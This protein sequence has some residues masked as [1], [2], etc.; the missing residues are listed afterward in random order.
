MVEIIRRATEI[1]ALDLAVW[2]MFYRMSRRGIRVD[3]GRL[4]A[5]HG[6]VVDLR[7]AAARKVNE[8]AGREINPNSGDE[9]AAW[10]VEHGFARGRKTKSKTRL[11][12]DEKALVG[13][14]YDHP[15]FDAVIEYRG[16]DKLRAAFIEPL[17]A[18]VAATDDHVVHP[19]WK[20]T[21]V[22]SGRAASEDPNLMAFPSRDELGREIRGCFVAR[23]GKMLFS[24]DYSQ[25]EPRLA[26]ALSSDEKLCAVYREGR[27]IYTET[28]KALF[29]IENVDPFRH[30]LP[31][32]VVTLGVMYGIG[33]EK[34]YESLIGW[35]AGDLIDGHF[36]PFFTVEECAELAAKWF[37]VYP[38]VARYIGR[39]CD[40]ARQEGG[41]VKTMRGRTRSLPA[42]FLM[43]GRWPQSKL[44][45]E[46]QRQAFNH[47]IQ[48]TAQEEMKLGMIRANGF[49]GVMDPL[50]QIHDEL[51]GEVAAEGSWGVVERIAKAM[52]AEVNGIPLK[53]SFKLA[54]N[55]GELK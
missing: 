27:D 9:V 8:A 41:V 28:A 36:K 37:Q 3:L 17:L 14:R 4:E 25:I 33:A 18:K 29:H 43:G 54:A 20:L 44:R 23:R 40:T 1:E 30:R 15:F 35:G 2:P 21:R 49:S 6:K 45:E 10:M 19:K 13:Y 52:E 39:V 47:V 11:S 22:R 53:T 42:L 48:G 12:T 24:V 32:K 26:A 7:T 46:A 5:L 34:L 31:A 50:L 16:H 38:G 55:W 51:V